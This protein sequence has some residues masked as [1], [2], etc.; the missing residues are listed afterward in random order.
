MALPE[1]G[2]VNLQQVVRDHE[3]RIEALELKGAV[4]FTPPQPKEHDGAHVSE[5]ASGDKETL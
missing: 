4:K 2:N 1:S 3:K 5:T